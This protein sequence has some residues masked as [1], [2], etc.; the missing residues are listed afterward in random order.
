METGITDC[1]FWNVDPMK[2]WVFTFISIR[3][4]IKFTE[5]L[6]VPKIMTELWKVILNMNNVNPHTIF[7]MLTT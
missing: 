4:M 7:A 1:H 6:Y 5:T 2:M 3:Y